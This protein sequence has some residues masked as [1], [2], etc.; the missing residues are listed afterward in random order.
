VRLI[1]SAPSGDLHVAAEVRAPKRTG[2]VLLSRERSQLV[3][4][5]KVLGGQLERVPGVQRSPHTRRWRS[6]LPS[7]YVRQR[8]TLIQPA[9]FDVVTVCAK[10]SSGLREARL[11]LVSDSAGGAVPALQR[12]TGD[13]YQAFAQQHGDPTGTRSSALNVFVPDAVATGRL[14]LRPNSYVSEITVDEQSRAKGAVYSDE[15][16]TTYE[17][18]ADALAA[19]AHLIGGFTNKTLRPLVAELLDQPYSRAAAATTCGGCA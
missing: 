14:D 5:L 2:P 7:A 1:E 11:Q 18:E 13:C 12:A 9:R 4:A 8:A 15:E 3:G 10:V 17:Q 19:T 16:G 6:G